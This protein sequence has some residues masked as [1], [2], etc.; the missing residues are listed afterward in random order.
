MPPKKNNATLSKP[1]EGS[2]T[3]HEEEEWHYDL[4]K[5]QGQVLDLVNS[6][7]ENDAELED[8]MKA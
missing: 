6:Q 7:R 3:T 2:T 4:S 1:L 5:L 8:N